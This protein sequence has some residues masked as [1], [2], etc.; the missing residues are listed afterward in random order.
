MIKKTSSREQIDYQYPNYEKRQRNN[1]TDAKVYKTKRACEVCKTSSTK[2]KKLKCCSKC[3]IVFYCSIKCQKEDWKI[4]KSMCGILKTRDK[5]QNKIEKSQKIGD[6]ASEIRNKKF[7]YEKL[8]KKVIRALRNMFLEKKMHEIS[9]TIEEIFRMVHTTVYNAAKSYKEQDENTL[10]RFR[11]HLSIRFKTFLEENKKEDLSDK[12]IL[13]FFNEDEL[14][15]FYRKVKRS[16]NQIGISNFSKRLKAHYFLHQVDIEIEFDHIFEKLREKEYF[17]KKE[18][19]Q[20]VMLMRLGFFNSMK[21][22]NKGLSDLSNIFSK[23]AFMELIK[24]CYGNN[25]SCIIFEKIF[26]VFEKCYAEN[27]K[28]N[29]QIVKELLKNPLFLDSKGHYVVMNS[30][31]KI[32]IKNHMLTIRSSYVWRDFEEKFMKMKQLV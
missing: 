29:A 6:W 24:I 28:S 10:K 22:A 32:A 13:E 3:K 11:D 9:Y 17:S 25:M 8:S 4:H 27:K 31:N 2:N 26:E 18:I 16:K 23:K 19:F 1:K 30:G 15:E 21:N 12:K 5:Y 14:R 20:V 7:T